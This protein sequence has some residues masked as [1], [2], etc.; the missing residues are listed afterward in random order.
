VN[1]EKPLTQKTPADSGSLTREPSG[2]QALS[3]LPRHL[4][5]ET[6]SSSKIGLSS[7]S[8]T[9]YLDTTFEI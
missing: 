8:K 5:Q 2:V 9:R 1:P 4:Q 7:C 6:P 3:S